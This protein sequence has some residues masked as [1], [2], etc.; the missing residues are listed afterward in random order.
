M[1]GGC[2]RARRRA[3]RRGGYG[4]ASAR[5][6]AF[7]RPAPRRPCDRPSRG[8]G[9]FMCP[10]ARQSALPGADLPTNQGRHAGACPCHPRRAPASSPTARFLRP[11]AHQII[12]TSY[13]DWGPSSSRC[14][15]MVERAAKARPRVVAGQGQQ[16]GG[17]HWRSQGPPGMDLRHIGGRVVSRRQLQRSLAP[18]RPAAAAARRDAPQRAKARPRTPTQPRPTQAEVGVRGLP[19]GCLSARLPAPARPR[20]PTNPTYPT[21]PTPQIQQTR[22]MFVPTLYFVDTS[23][24][25]HSPGDLQSHVSWWCYTKRDGGCPPATWAEVSQFREGM[26]R[27]FRRAVDKG[28]SIA[29]APHVDDGQYS[30]ARLVGWLRGP[31]WAACAVGPPRNCPLPFPPTLPPPRPVAKRPGV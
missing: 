15:D 25:D 2:G 28:L 3:G 10:C 18:G 4:G 24:H 19:W 21:P 29:V 26:T 1:R 16:D 11:P 27:C 30:G 13:D 22:L 31:A 14:L 6:A 8:N 12:M 20:P 9:N 7:D 23:W 5:R 17:W